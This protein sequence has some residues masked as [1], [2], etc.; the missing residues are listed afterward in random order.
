MLKFLKWIEAF[1]KTYK[2]L[3]YLRMGR[4]SVAEAAERLGVHVQRVHQRI[5]DGSLPAEK[6]GSSWVIDEVDVSRIDK[7]PSGRPPSA[8][9]AWNIVVLAAG[10]GADLPP[11]RLASAEHWLRVLQR[12]ARDASEDAVAAELRRLLR[13]RASRRAYHA[14]PRDLDDLRQDPRVNLS[15]VSDPGSGL[16]S[17][18]VVEGYVSADVA[19]AVIDGYLLVPAASDL[20]NVVAHVYDPDIA[21]HDAVASPS[22]LLV[23]ADLAE[24]HGARES[25]RAAQLIRDSGM[26]RP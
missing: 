14:S 12:L 5:A 25:A 13:N 6:I 2:W 7:R 3:Q 16:A 1:Q 24:H 9:S 11:G 19:D 22:H 15:G 23:A 8:R 17:G 4:I 21:P 18:D 10:N 20:A 26:T